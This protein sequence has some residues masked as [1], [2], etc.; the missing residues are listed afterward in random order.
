MGGAGFISN[1]MIM[2]FQWDDHFARWKTDEFRVPYLY[3]PASEIWVPDVEIFN[4]HEVHLTGVAEEKVKVFNNG[5]CQWTRKLVL[6][7]KCA[8]NLT[9]FP[10]DVQ[11][12]QIFFGPTTLPNSQQKLTFTLLPDDGLPKFDA[13][14]FARMA[15]KPPNVTE[16]EA[17]WPVIGDVEYTVAE[18]NVVLKREQQFYMS[19]G[20]MPVILV[21]GIVYLSS[22]LPTNMVERMDFGAT[23]LL[24][25]VAVMFVI[26]DKL[27]T[28]ED[29]TIMDRFF[30]LSMVFNLIAL[31]ESAIV[32]TF[33]CNADFKSLKASVGFFLNPKM[34]DKIMRYVFPIIYVIM[35]YDMLLL[36]LQQAAG[37]AGEFS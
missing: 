9:S 3:I 34:L 35:L 37:F 24:S 29:M 7:S 25:I 30:G 32:V 1:S 27:P 23:A 5:T 19:N 16:Y 26:S 11:N 4:S 31:V 14:S 6:D 2:Q 22:Y 13:L 8:F 21:T 33:A 12:C 18:Y 36:A 15:T 20:V 17:R 28:Q 10:F